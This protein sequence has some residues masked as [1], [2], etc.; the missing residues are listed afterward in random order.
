MSFDEEVDVLVAGT[1]AAGCAAALGA[2]TSG[3][4][5]VLVC[6][7]SKRLVGGTTKIAGGGWLWC[8]NNPF[9]A[10]LGVHQDPAEI[11]NLLKNLAYPEGFPHANDVRLMEAF[12]EEWPAVVKTLMDNK[13]MELQAVEVRDEEDVGRVEALIRRKM[14]ADPEFTAKT[15]ISEKNIKSLAKLM[16][17]YCAEHDLDLC[18]SGKVLA[19]SGGTTSRQLEKAVRSF[20]PKTEIRMGTQ[21]VDIVFEE[22]RVVGAVVKDMKSGEEKRIRVRNGVIFGSGGYSGNEEMKEKYFGR[23]FVPMG[24]CSAKTNTGDFAE[25][26][27]KHSI[28][29]SG[30]DKAWL[31]QVVLPFKRERVG[32]FFLNADSYMVVDRTGKRFACEKDFYQQR[33]MQ[34]FQN[35]ERRCVFFVF[36]HRSRDAFEGPIKGLGG[37]IPFKEQEEDCL[38]E[39]SNVEELTSAIRSKLAEVAPGFELASDFA[40]SL[41]AQLEKYNGFANS[42]KDPEFARG[43]DVAQYCWHT[44]RAE[45]NTTPNKT[46]FPIDM[47]SLKCVIMGL[48]TLDTKGGPEITRNGQVLGQTG[49][50]ITG[51]YG[52]GNCVRSSTSFSY[53]ASG[54]TLS[55]AILF[56]FLGG[57]HAMAPSKS[58]L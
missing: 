9:L 37:P 52:A 6:E 42:G 44:P 56:G 57:R 1:G 25:I 4:S 47:K 58:K 13:F 10:A 26:A 17:S 11:Q 21:V 46:M 22:D 14:A 31:K 27:R 43:D 7:K 51:L 49:L 45:G 28:P 23:K 8:P 53:P 32:V 29:L 30:M 55:N 12:A 3:A 5:K 35:P 19:P 15:G 20:E 24:T 50:P 41:Q 18:P 38:L 36:D 40:K 54:V 48:S 34:M 33:G 16:P 39:G 2:V